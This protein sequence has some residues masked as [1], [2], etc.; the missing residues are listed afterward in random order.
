MACTPISN[1]H[2]HT[3]RILFIFNLSSASDRWLL[4]VERSSSL[5]RVDRISP[6]EM[7]GRQGCARPYSTL[8]LPPLCLRGHRAN[9]KIQR[10]KNSLLE[11]FLPRWNSIPE[12]IV[13]YNY[14]EQKTRVCLFV[15]YF[16]KGESVSFVNSIVIVEW[17][18]HERWTF[19]HW[20]EIL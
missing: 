7:T 1:E 17:L 4:F 20:V 18:N 8:T 5:A 11:D 10:W 3:N 15:W 2:T 6:R 9:N 14:G 12:S 19:S 13:S 16:V